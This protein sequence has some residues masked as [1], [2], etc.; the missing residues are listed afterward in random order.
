MKFLASQAIYLVLAV[1]AAAIVLVGTA[2][3]GYA[4]FSWFASFMSAGWAAAVVAVVLLVPVFTAALIVRD[5]A[6]EPR[7][8]QAAAPE[9]AAQDPM[10]GVMAA[11][12]GLAEKKPL[13]AAGAAILLGIATTYLGSKSR[14]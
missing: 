8:A 7:P 12:A 5:R 11:I 3:G 13:W 1:W 9:T 14:R 6:Q 10:A 4:L 2:F